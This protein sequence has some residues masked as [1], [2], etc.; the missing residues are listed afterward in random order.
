[1]LL[2]EPVCTKKEKKEPDICVYCIMVNN[3]PKEMQNFLFPSSGTSEFIK[4]ISQSKPTTKMLPGVLCTHVF[5][6]VVFG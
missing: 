6:G 5:Y 3:L 4:V 1:M 2:W